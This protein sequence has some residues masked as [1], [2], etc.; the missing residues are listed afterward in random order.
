[1]HLL[2]LTCL[3]HMTCVFVL[4]CFLLIWIVCVLRL[5]DQN[6]NRT[7]YHSIWVQFRDWIILSKFSVLSLSFPLSLLVTLRDGNTKK[8]LHGC[9]NGYFWKR[10]LSIQMAPNCPAAKT[11][12]LTWSQQ[13]SYS[14]QD[15]SFTQQREAL[16][17]WF[18][19]ISNSLFKTL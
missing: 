15:F 1:M 10:N 16:K 2:S 13:W 8:N 18:A 6:S 7:H 14:G 12:P 9:Y 11:L 17:T 3:P 4:F 5:S 19:L